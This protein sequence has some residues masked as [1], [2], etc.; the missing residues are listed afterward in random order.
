VNQLVKKLSAFME[1]GGLQIYS[2]WLMALFGF[3]VY[4]VCM[5]FVSKGQE[6]VSEVGA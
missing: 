6:S 2:R 1:C 3:S 5:T 4:I